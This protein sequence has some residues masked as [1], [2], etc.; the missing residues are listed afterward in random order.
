VNKVLIVGLSNTHG[1]VESVIINFFRH[2]D[3]KKT[4][5][6]FLTIVDNPS[7]KDEILANGGEI[8]RITGRGENAYKFYKEC[9]S[10]F[11][12]HAHEYSA[13]WFNTCMLSNLVYLKYAKRYGIK[14]RIIHAHVSHNIASFFHFLLH[15][16]NKKIVSRYATDFWACDESAA[17]YTFPRRAINGARSRYRL[18]NNAIDTCRFKYNEESRLKIR[19]AMGI[20][21]NAIVFGHVGRMDSGKNQEFVIEIFS[22]ILRCKANS[23]LLLVGDGPDLEKLKQYSIDMGIQ[24]N[25]I[26]LGR[27][28]DVAD[29]LSAMDVFVFPSKYESFGISLLEAECS[30]LMCY[31][32]DAVPL[33]ACVCDNVERI[34]LTESAEF[35]ANKILNHMLLD[36]NRLTYSQIIK[37]KGFDIVHEAHKVQESFITK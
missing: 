29:I 22:H 19:S 21:R 30:G 4:Q 15:C 27:R 16:M 23:Y 10:F 36:Q 5:F 35:W 1:G 37:E 20:E 25:I 8:Y 32:S 14:K 18:I 12:N 33:S 13:I 24:N 11:K 9:K 28:N 17:K 34:S 26:F 31:T 6:D 2:F 3:K 7:Y